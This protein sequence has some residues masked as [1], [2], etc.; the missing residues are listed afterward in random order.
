MLRRTVV[1]AAVSLIVLALAIFL[2]LTLIQPLRQNSSVAGTP[3][4]NT[5]G[6]QILDAN[7]NAVY[8][9]GIGRAGDLDSLSGT[10]G[11]QGD[12][13]YSYGEK[14]QTDIRH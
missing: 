13:V 1:L 6:D 4:L 11:G 3:A 7:N 2:P 12:A 14:W 5:S 10:W 8:L 9:R